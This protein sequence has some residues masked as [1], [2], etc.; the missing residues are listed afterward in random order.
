MLFRKYISLFKDLALLILWNG[1]GN[2]AHLLF[3]VPKYISLLISE[4]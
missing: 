2:E 1:I 3:N 4:T